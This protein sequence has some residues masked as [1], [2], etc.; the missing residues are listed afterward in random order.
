MIYQ[1]LAILVVL[2]AAVLGFVVFVLARRPLI[3]WLASC[4][5]VPAYVLFGEF[6]ETHQAGGGASMWL[7][8]LVFGGAYGAVAGGIGVFIGSLVARRR[9]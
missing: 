7:V 6:T 9:A 4:A 8:A 2:L 1:A 3:A 5:V